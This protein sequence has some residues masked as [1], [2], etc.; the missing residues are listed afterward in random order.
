MRKKLTATICVFSGF[1]ICVSLL[2]S[3]VL[4]ATSASATIT[5]SV[6]YTPGIQAKIWLNDGEND[7]LIFNNVDSTALYNANGV[8]VTS[9]AEGIRLNGY[10]A[11]NSTTFTLKVANHSTNVGTTN[12]QIYIGLSVA[13]ESGSVKAGEGSSTLTGANFVSFDDAFLALPTVTSGTNTYHYFTTPIA[14]N[15][16]QVS[17]I[18]VTPEIAIP[19]TLDFAILLFDTP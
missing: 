2:I 13:G 7:M 17:T 9:T 19:G 11:P 8:N 1:L 18:S 5:A 15:Q 12:N 16:T 14:G 6:S 10:S 4:A 3:S